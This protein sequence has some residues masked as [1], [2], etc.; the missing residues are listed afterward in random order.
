[1]KKFQNSK[2]IGICL[3]L[4]AGITS[5]SPF[6]DNYPKN[7]KVDAINYAFKLELSDDTDEIVCE[8]VIDIIYRGAGVEYLRSQRPIGGVILPGANLSAVTGWSQPEWSGWNHF[9]DRNEGPGIAGSRSR[10]RLRQRLHTCQFCRTDSST[11][12]TT[13]IS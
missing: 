9:W 1:M 10:L 7:P 3:F 5:A 11:T 2:I 13:S 6:N 4:L 12:T 8:V